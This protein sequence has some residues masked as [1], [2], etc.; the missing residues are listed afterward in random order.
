MTSGFSGSPA[1]THSRSVRCRRGQVGLDQH[2]PDRRRRAQRGDP[3]AADGVEQSRRGEPLVA[4]DERGRPGV[5]RREHVLHACFAQ[6]GEEMFRC[7][8]PGCRPI[9][10]MVDRCPAGYDAWVCSTSLGCAVVPEVKYSSSG[11]SARVGPSGAK[12]YGCRTPRVR[13]P[14]SRSRRAGP[15]TAILVSPRPGPRT[16]RRQAALGDHVPD[17]AALDPVGQV[18][19]AEQGRGRDDHR[20][21][22]HRGQHGLPQRPMLPSISSTRS[23]RRTPSP[24]SQLAT[25]LDRADSSA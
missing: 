14:A 13:A 17:V 10:Y 11:S 23:P 3:A 15:P 9:Q 22:L 2:P 24:R 4:Q 6:P 8:S 19:G 21:E 5:P 18:V 25:W 7:T 1:P 16:W 12:P 20:A